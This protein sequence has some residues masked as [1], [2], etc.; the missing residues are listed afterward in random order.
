MNLD[1]SAEQEELREAARNFA[2]GELRTIGKE[3]EATIDIQK[4]NIAAALIGRRFNQ[5]AL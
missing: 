2:T 5:R 1:L 4:I 3:I